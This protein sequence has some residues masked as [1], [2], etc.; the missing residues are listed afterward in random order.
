MRRSC[1]AF[2]AV[3]GFDH[4]DE[5]RYMNPASRLALKS[6]IADFLEG[7]VLPIETA[8]ALRPFAEDVPGKLGQDL[9]NMAILISSETDDIP[10]GHRRDLWH[11][12]VR[13]REDEKHD[14][15]QAWAEPIVCKMCGRLL[16]SL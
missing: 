11:P 5:Y 7:R 14:H 6:I 16:L 13:A 4:V 15:A 2:L 3:A 9:E 10:L 12:D 1:P 8:F